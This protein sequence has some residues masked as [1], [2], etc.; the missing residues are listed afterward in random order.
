MAKQKQLSQPNPEP[1]T[2]IQNASYMMNRANSGESR[3]LDSRSRSP[4]WS[5]RATLSSTSLILGR[6]QIMLVELMR[7]IEVTVIKD[8]SKKYLTTPWLVRDS[9]NM[10]RI[11]NSMP[12]IRVAIFR[13]PL[14]STLESWEAQLKRRSKANSSTAKPSRISCNPWSAQRMVLGAP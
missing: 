10:L 12:R 9:S 8:R 11:S 6:V 5:R 1:S 3:L 4:I 13:S 14:S 2:C 7:P